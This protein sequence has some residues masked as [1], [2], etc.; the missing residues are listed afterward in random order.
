MLHVAL[1]DIQVSI[2]IMVVLVKFSAFYM[3]IYLYIVFPWIYTSTLLSL[4]VL[5]SNVTDL[6]ACC[7][8]NL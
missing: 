4:M 6:T 5:L 8:F 1:I 3:H 7:A 2:V